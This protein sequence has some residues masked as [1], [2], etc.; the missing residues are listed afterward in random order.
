MTEQTQGFGAHQEAAPS[1]NVPAVEPGAP[2]TPQFVTMD[3]LRQALTE[4]TE[5]LERRLQSLTDKQENRLKGEVDKRV[6]AMERNYQALGMS[7]PAEARQRIIDETV[8][9]YLDD[10]QPQASQPA[11][12][13]KELVA[14]VNRKAQKIAEK[15]GVVLGPG[16]PEFSQVNQATADPDEYLESWERAVTSKAE[17]L[18][19]GQPP[20][21][22]TTPQHNPAARAPIA[23]SGT[24]GGQDLMQKY[25]Q[26]AA[27]LRPGSNELLQLRR[28]YR[29]LGLEL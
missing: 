11:A 18:R 24:P 16:D 3:L 21:Q 14:Y 9:S 25:K 2:E 19:G 15:A 1:G 4:Q 7:V 20:N 27:N 28:D 10:E 17:R 26:E 5:K 22:P 6:K 23:G 12:P 29:K 13:S 8:L